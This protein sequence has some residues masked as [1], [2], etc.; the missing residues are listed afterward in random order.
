MSGGYLI[1]FVNFLDRVDVIL[2]FIFIMVAMYTSIRRW[3]RI[4]QRNHDSTFVR[5]FWLWIKRVRGADIYSV[6]NSERNRII[7]SR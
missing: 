5:K 4:H 2:A 1:F 7:D 6:S 3:W